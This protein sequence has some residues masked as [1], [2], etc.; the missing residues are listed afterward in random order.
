[1]LLAVFL[2][3]FVNLQDEL[4]HAVTSDF[5]FVVEARA[6][7]QMERVGAFFLGGAF[8]EAGAL[9]SQAK[10]DDVRGLWRIS[11]TKFYD[12]LHVNTFGSNEPPRHLEIL[13]VFDLDVE[14]ARVLDGRALIIK[15]CRSGGGVLRGRLL[16]LL[17][18]NV[19]L[20]GGS[21]LGVEGLIIRREGLCRA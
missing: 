13:V 10:L 7:A 19:R 16:L 1:M 5:I 20:E 2:V 15:I 21:L 17:G 4:L 9:A 12:T 6:D 8:A 18:G 11:A 3:L 14:P